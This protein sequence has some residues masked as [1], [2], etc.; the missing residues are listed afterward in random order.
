MEH[1]VNY[2]IL[3]WSDE[4]I[5]EKCGENNERNGNDPDDCIFDNI[6]DTEKMVK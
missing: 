1:S 6:W 5:L 2:S 4:N 3:Y